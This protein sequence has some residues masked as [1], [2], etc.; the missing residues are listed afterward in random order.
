MVCDCYRGFK[1]K[2]RKRLREGGKGIETLEEEACTFGEMELLHGACVILKGEPT[3]M[4][5]LKGDLSLI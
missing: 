3:C 5:G 4:C 1:K 2:D